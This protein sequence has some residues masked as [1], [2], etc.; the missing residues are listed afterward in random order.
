MMT[1]EQLEQQKLSK[2]TDAYNS[3]ESQFTPE[4]QKFVTE[5]LSSKLWRLNN[6]YKIRDK[7]ANLITL[8]LNASQQKVLKEFKHNKKIILKSRQQGISTLYLA[9]YL[10]TCLFT[11][12]YQAG[13]QSYGQDESDKLSKRAELMWN[14]LSQDI[15][16]LFGLKLVSNNQKGMTF[17][18]GSILKIG[19]FRGDTLQALHVSELGKIAKKFP[20]KAKELKSGAFQAVSTKNKITI[21]STAEGRSGLFYDMWRKAE[22]LQLQ[23]KELTS[24][25]FQAIFLSWTADPDCTLDTEVEIPQAL[26]DYF[27]GIEETLGVKLEDNQKWWYVKKKEELREDMTQEYPTTSDEAF[28]AARDGSY[29]GRLYRDH[30]IKNRRIVK[31]LF[32]NT[33]DVNVAMDLGMRDTFVMVFYQQFKNELRIIDCYYN[34]GEPLKHYVEVLKTLANSKDYNYGSIYVPHDAKVVELGTGKSR[35]QILRDYGVISTILPKI[36]VHTGIELVRKWMMNMYID[37]ELDYIQDMF[38]NYS[39]QWDDR[40]GVWKDKPLHDEWSNPADAVRYMCL[41]LQEGRSKK[42]T[43]KKA[44]SG[45]AV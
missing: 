29:Y 5:K 35:H 40:L 37:S 41:S 42:R 23:G 25:D 24:L 21:E 38:V 6:L 9:Y 15:K 45:F 30:I 20:E 4:Q 10:D 17:S 13:I 1:A 28:A 18:N 27:T 32:D 39:K 8:K 16:D 12:G 44:V 2:L 43:M 22:E 33:L 26:A 14:E 3:T 11:P 31:D 7:D 19:N 34:S 36:D